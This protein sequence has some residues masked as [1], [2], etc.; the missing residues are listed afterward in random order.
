MLKNNK[1]LVILLIINFI[2]FSGCIV[3]YGVENEVTN[4]NINETTEDDDNTSNQV[5]KLYL[6]V[7][8]V[9]MKV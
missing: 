9:D 8:N 6:Y 1:I 5:I 4:E 7:M 3:S 2:L